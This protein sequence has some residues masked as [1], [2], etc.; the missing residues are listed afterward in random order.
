MTTDT[1]DG[2]SRR[3]AAEEDGSSGQAGWSAFD[4]GPN[5]GSP[6]ERADKAERAIYSVDP[7]ARLLLDRLGIRPYVMALAAVA[8]GV[9]F[10]LVIP[11][12]C[13]CLRSEGR[14]LGS[15]G[16]WHAQLL[17]LLVFPAACAF[18]VWQPGAIAQVYEAM[19]L[20]Q[21]LVEVGGGYRRKVW[22]WLS[23]AL[24]VAIV[25]FDSPK[26]VANYGTW[27]MSRN[28]LTIL[29]REA[30]L[31][32]A[33]YILSMMAWRQF[34]ATL[35]WRRLLPS[36]ATETGLRAASAYGLSWALLLA[37]L[38]L[39]LSVEA[40]ELPRRA[41][42]ITPDYYAKVAAYVVASVGFFCA[43]TWGLLGRDTAF[44]SHRLRTWLELAGIVALPLL[45]FVVLKLVLGP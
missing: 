35:E 43:P 12:A 9:V 19:G 31:A 6:R 14:F 25:L 15:L 44:S 30:S 16:D 37:L 4:G 8:W 20:R 38:G 13:G 39:R 36:Q 1:G 5:R 33:F 42:A 24:G 34:V 10:L 21:R 11:A 7:L 40:I 3:R 27:W 23:I 26:M 18:Y 29:G 45:G 41:G 17:L 32:F 22:L 28:W 2:D